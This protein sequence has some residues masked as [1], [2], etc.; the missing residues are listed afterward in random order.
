MERTERGLAFYGGYLLWSAGDWA[1]V[2]LKSE[3]TP[4]E[5]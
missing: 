5:M 1:F 2:S 4:L 3:R